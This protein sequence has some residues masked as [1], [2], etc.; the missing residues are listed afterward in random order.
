MS[1]LSEAAAYAEAAAQLARDATDGR[2]SLAAR[3]HAREVLAVMGTPR[4]ATRILYFGSREW[5]DVPRGW[6]AEQ[7]RREARERGRLVLGPRRDDVDRALQE[8]AAM[9]DKNVVIIEGEADGADVTARILARRM[10][11]RVEPYP[12][13]ATEWRDLGKKA[14]HVRNGRMLRDGKPEMARGFI[15][16]CLNGPMSRG[17]TDMLRRLLAAGIGVILRRDDGVKVYKGTS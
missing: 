4:R 1:E 9:Y 10:G 11:L 5:L 12:V 17:S 16:G 7:V 6:T 2:R 3:R 14:G 8:D 15:V 13:T